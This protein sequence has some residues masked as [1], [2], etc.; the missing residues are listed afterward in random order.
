MN[1]VIYKRKTKKKAHENLTKMSEQKPKTETLIKKSDQNAQ[2][3]AANN[4][5]S[6]KLNK[7]LE[8]RIENDKV[9]WCDLVSI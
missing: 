8:S 4:P 2:N 3:T 6:R 5:I 9:N 1:V 7:I